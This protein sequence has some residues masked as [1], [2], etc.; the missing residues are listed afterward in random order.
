MTDQRKRRNAIAKD[1]EFVPPIIKSDQAVLDA[2]W[3]TQTVV[4]PPIGTTP[5]EKLHDVLHAKINGAK[6]QQDASFKTGTVLIQ[7][8]YAFFKFNKFYDKLKAK[9]WKY[10]E[11][12]TGTMMMKT[13]KDCE[14]EFLGEKRFPSTKEGKYNT[15]TKNI[16]KISVK[17]FENVPIHHTQIKHKTEIL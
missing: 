3:K 17:E 5:K 12:K 16:V 6:A 8:G 14:I 7:D 2:L 15:P 1:A 11:D 4:S 9:D 10:S 13:Y